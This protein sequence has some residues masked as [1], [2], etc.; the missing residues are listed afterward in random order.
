[1]P[2]IAA[3]CALAFAA[4]PWAAVSWFAAS[5]LAYVG[6]VAASQRRQAREGPRAASIATC[7]AIPG[8]APDWA[9]VLAGAALCAVGLGTK[10]WASRSLPEGAYHWR[11]FFVTG[12]AQEFSRRG[13]Y[14][15]LRDPMY[16]VGYAH[17]YGFALAFR[18]S[19]GL[20]CAACAQAAM[21]VLNHVVERPDLE[22]ANGR[23]A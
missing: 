2:S 3:G 17:A 16:T 10:V 7:A 5:P 18:S 20:V 12:E 21:L 14:R 9:F 23:T 19:T 6:F 15:W 8:V 22:R 11:N 13:P 4:P 1:V